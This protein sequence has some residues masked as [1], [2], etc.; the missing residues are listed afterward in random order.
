M[1]VAPCGGQR[2][3]AGPHP[4][5]SARCADF[6]VLLGPKSAAGLARALRALR[7]DSRG[8]SDTKR[9]DARRPRSCA[10]RR[11][12]NRTVRAPLAAALL[13]ARDGFPLPAWRGGAGEGCQSPPARR[14]A[15][16][17]PLPLRFGRAPGRSEARPTD[18]SASAARVQ[19]ECTCDPEGVAYT[20]T[21]PKS[22]HPKVPVESSPLWTGVRRARET[23]PKA[24]AR[25]KPGPN[26]TS[27]R[28]TRRGTRCRGLRVPLPPSLARR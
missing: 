23:Q 26:L 2:G 27:C 5:R 19:S 11:P 8:K 25:P 28:P 14:E 10:A 13:H 17:V 7:S 4:G 6:A 21:L 12:G 9:A 18:P 20:R 16:W 22:G 24:G 15:G 1:P 3:A